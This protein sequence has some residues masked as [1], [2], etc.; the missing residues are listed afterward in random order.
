MSLLG[1]VF[2]GQGSQHVGMLQSLGEEYSQIL[3]TFNEASD[4]LGYDLWTLAQEGPQETLDQTQFTQPVLLTVSVAMHRLF[5]ALV[6]VNFA[7]F[8]G[9]SLGEYSAYV[10]AQSLSFKD[11]IKL[12]ETRG[13]LMQSTV[14]PGVGAMA[15]IVGLDDAVV[16]E[17]CESA[18]Q[19]QIVA[20]ANYNSIGQVVIAGNLEAVERAILI[21][22]EQGVRLAT[23][24]AVSV[25][26]HC[27]MMK[28]AAEAFADALAGVQIK[29][30]TVP[31]ISNVHVS[32][33]SDPAQIR[34]SLVEQLYKPVRWVETIGFM[35]QQGVLN[36]IEC[37]PGKVLGG[38]IKRINRDMSVLSM[39]DV[40]SLNKTV[41]V[42][43]E[44]GL[45]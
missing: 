40:S 21:A 28:P 22:S 39:N 1:M 17:I 20:P 23:K 34:H 3:D 32:I 10:C 26:A 41:L 19:G 36:L 27:E 14:K 43:E 15:A 11:A 44:G 25:P 35:E 9:H 38:L 13:R 6:R 29:A 18:A 24:L 33:M 30:P 45:I 4:I 8:A 2:P 16:I 42:C 12:V 37:G 5:R 31:V 7:M